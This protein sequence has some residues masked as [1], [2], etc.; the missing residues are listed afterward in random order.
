MVREY[1]LENRDI[2]HDYLSELSKKNDH[3]LRLI[4]IH[5]R[6]NYFIA[7]S[8]YRVAEFVA[9]KLGIGVDTAFEIVNNIGIEKLLFPNGDI[10]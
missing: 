6:D 2:I 8:E 10:K 5:E 7:T 1:I 3:E 9:G 4:I